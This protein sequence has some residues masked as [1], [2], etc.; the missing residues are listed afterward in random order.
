MSKLPAY[1]ACSGYESQEGETSQAAEDGTRLHE[2]LDK[3][4]S[5]YKA[6]TDK[7]PLTDRLYEEFLAGQLSCD[8]DELHLLDFCTK[9]VDKFLKSATEIDNEIRVTIFKPD[10][11]ELNYGSLDVRLDLGRGAALVI[12]YKFGWIPVEHARSNMQGKGYALG[13]LQECSQFQTVSVMFLQPKLNT[14][15]TATFKREQMYEMYA[16]IEAIISAAQAA[17]KTLRPNPYCDF[18]KHAAAPCTALVKTASAVVAKY[19]APD[20]PDIFDGLTITKPEQALAAFYLLDRLET[21]ISKGGIR[22]KALEMAQ[23]AGGKLSA[24]IGGKLLTLEVKHRKSA[25]SA[26]S[27]AMIADVLKDVLTP[28]QVLGCCD[29]SITKLEEVFSEEYVARAKAEA[30]AVLQS[31]EKEA[32]NL[33]DKKLASQLLKQAKETA[34]SLRVT[35]KAAAEIL[36]D[37]LRVEGLVTSGEGLVPYLKLKVESPLLLQTTDNTQNT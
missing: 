37:T 21:L 20:I 33:T 19:D 15:T 3:L 14:V 24:E 25:R 28:E 32:A 5:D 7:R 16:E 6:S 35:K 2:I 22:Q 1:K 8:E 36:N 26:N 9:N 23:A 4:I 17:N 29:P 31:A 18:C 30:D 11:S 34:K 13:T 27:P 10:G 12:D